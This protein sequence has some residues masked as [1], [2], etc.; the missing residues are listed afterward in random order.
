M[1]T[2]KQTDLFMETP[3]FRQYQSECVKLCIKNNVMVILPT[4]LGKTV[5]AA[6]VI[7]ACFKGGKALLLAPTTV[8]L[9]QHWESMNKF[10]KVIP[11]II[12]GDTSMDKRKE[13]FENSDI[14]I[15]TP[16]TIKSDIL[17]ERYLPE[18]IDLI[19]YDEAHH[20]SGDYDYTWI[21]QQFP[22]VHACGFTA[23]PGD[24][25]DE[26][27]RLL[28]LKKIFYRDE[29]DPDVREYVQ[30]I[31]SLRVMVEMPEEYRELETFLLEQAKILATPIDEAMMK[32]WMKN[33]QED[34][35]SE[36]DYP[37]MFEDY[38]NIR[39]REVLA[40]LD[41]F[42]N[43]KWFPMIS[44][45]ALL[46]SVTHALELL[47]TQD[48]SVLYTYATEIWKDKSKKPS[49]AR[50]QFYFMLK[51]VM[52]IVKKA[53]SIDHPKIPITRD[54]IL[55]E[56]SISPNNKALVFVQYRN[57]AAFIADRL[58]DFDINTWKFVGK[59]SKGSTKGLT[60]KQQEAFLAFFKCVTE[61]E[62][63][64]CSKKFKQQYKSHFFKK[65]EIYSPEEMVKRHFPVNAL[66]ATQVIEEGMDV[67]EVGLVINY[68]PVPETIRSIQRRG[69]TGRKTPGKVKFLI[70]KGS[71]DE[72]VYWS[73]FHALKKEKKRL[74]GKAE[75]GIR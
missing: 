64:E 48:A 19:L 7:N 59:A 13:I 14:I 12:C 10:C 28:N 47:R 26:I 62:A 57:S 31:E 18:G 32:V 17:S 16:Q 44:K 23:S 51:E 3:E 29:D 11:A 38:E 45:T 33:H 22:K 56:L 71:T 15:A 69:R 58:C 67:A 46:M 40:C 63:L 34:E 50:T 61:E 9:D 66:A 55:D 5:I 73:T 1:D 8:L 39:K 52:P 60:K 4:A 72:G 68:E 70:T 53:C 43:L 30:M 24:R 49:K 42:S 74:K 20:A 75:N 36:D 65:D 37:G 41:V 21:A 2:G 35:P 27:M 54:L 6:E 25:E